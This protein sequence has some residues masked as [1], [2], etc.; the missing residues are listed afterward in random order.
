LKGAGESKCRLKIEKREK[1][2]EGWGKH[3]GK[4]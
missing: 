2:W 3:E 4:M 1:K